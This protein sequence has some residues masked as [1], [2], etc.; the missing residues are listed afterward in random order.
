MK[1]MAGKIPLSLRIFSIGLQLFLFAVA[2]TLFAHGNHGGVAFAMAGSVPLDRLVGQPPILN[3]AANQQQVSQIDRTG[4]YDFLKLNLSFTA[5]NAGYSTQPTVVGSNGYEQVLN[6]IQNVT[7]TATGNAAGST[8]DTMINTD[9]V[10]MGV[11]QY[12]YSNG[13]LPGTPFAAFANSAQNVSAV[14][15]AFFVDPWSNKPTLTRL[16]SRLLSQLNLSVSWRDATSY[17]AGG[18]AGTTT[19][20]NGQVVLSVREW[21]NVP[22]IIRPWLRMSDRKQQIVAQQNASQIQGVPIGNVIRR[23]LVQGIVPAVTGYNYGWSSA[24]AFASTGQAQGPMYQLLINNS[25]K[26]L[27]ESFADLL[28]DNPQLLSITQNNW[29]TLS[30]AIPGW[31]VYEPARQKKLS[32]SLP[33]WGVNRADNFVDVAAPGSFGSYLKITDL[34]L[35]GATA[36]TLS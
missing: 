10:T 8:T 36:A 31:Y 18:V 20:S 12:Y 25:T 26:V 5:T 9:F 15:K 27:N 35:V 17:S 11:Y 19:V 28:A 13:C 24:A 6:M 32:Q 1:L 16:D 3:F 34:E 22:Q 29:G 33:M 2:I 14:V 23:E 21:Q 30:G 7:L 4:L